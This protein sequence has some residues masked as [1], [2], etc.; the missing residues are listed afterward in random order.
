[1]VDEAFLDDEVETLAGERHEGLVVL[2]SLT[3]IWS[4]PGIRAGYLL[5][6]PHVVEALRKQQTPWSVSAPAIAALVATSSDQAV[7]EARARAVELTSRREHLLEGLAELGIETVPST[8]PYV[9]ART[10]AGS[11]EALRSAGFATRRADTFPGLDDEWV[12]I[13]ARRTSVTDDLLGAL[14]SIH[15]VLR[16]PVGIRHSGA[17][18]TRLQRTTES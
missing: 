18:V 10:G 15:P 7:Q 12:R 11:R 16:K 14:R 8:A 5:A 2:R 1:V 6:D 17:T 3:K 4:I 13:S 9:L